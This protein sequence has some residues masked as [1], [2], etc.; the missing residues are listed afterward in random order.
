MSELKIKAETLEI[1]VQVAEARSPRW[2][3]RA[4]GIIK[5]G[6]LYERYEVPRK[7]FRDQT[8]YQRELSTARVNR[9]VKDLRD[10]RVDLPTSVLVN[11]RGF[12]A[13]RNL[14]TENGQF[15]LRLFKDKLHV[16]DGQH[17]VAALVKLID[18][19]PDRWSDFEI[20]FVSMLGANERDE[21]REFYVVNSNAKSVRTDLAYD[22]LK[23]QAEAD[24]VIQEGVVASGQAWKVK[25]QTLAEELNNVPLWRGLIRYPGEP[26]ANTTIGSASI[27]NSLKPLFSVSF[28]DQM[29]TQNQ[30]KVL[31]AYWRGVQRAMPEPFESPGDYAL[32]KGIGTTV[33]HG[34]FVAV[35]EHVRVQGRSIIEPQPYADLLEQVLPN[36]QGDTPTGD[37]VTG[38]DF[39]RTG[40]EGAAGSYSSSAGQRVL[41]AKLKA[42]LPPIDVM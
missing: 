7:N 23:H 40:S 4:T 34:L 26:K 17:R 30:L 2:K 11:L 13:D 16:V 39:W 5:A 32:Q 10:D 33:M 24:P 12:N 18:E 35:L 6:D 28:F 21:M 29:T 14:Y 37:I 25:G 8:G 27:V 31:D 9:L 3:P 41:N 38:E 20:A 15:F 36:L 42:L 22:L 1:P 19:D